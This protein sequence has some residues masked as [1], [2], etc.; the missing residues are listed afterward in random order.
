[1]RADRPQRRRQDHAVPR[2]HGR[3]SGQRHGRAR[4]DRS[5]GAAAASCASR[6]ASA[7]CRKIAGWCPNSRSR[8]TSGCP[9]CRSRWSGADQRLDWIFG[10]M[11]E[12]A[13]FPC[14]PCAGIVGRTAED[15]RAGAG[16]DGG[17]PHACCSTSRSRAWRRRWR[18]GWA[19]CWR[20][21]RPRGL[22]ADRGI[23][24]GACRRSAVARLSHR[25]RLGEPGI[26]KSLAGA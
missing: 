25:A 20:T 8:K 23:Q 10:L 1:M 11:P 24:R 4:H 21:S 22:G 2:H 5:V 26:T 6:T 9:R 7:I 19:R 3:D 18:G 12:V 16:A 17:N 14:P 15:G 13:A